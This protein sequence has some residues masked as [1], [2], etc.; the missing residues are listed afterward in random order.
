MVCRR[1]LPE[2]CREGQ[3]IGP[4]RVFQAGDLQDK[5]KGRVGEGRNSLLR[6]MAMQIMGNKRALG[7]GS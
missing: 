4:R 2:R 6:G 7:G 5:K 1:G 3:G